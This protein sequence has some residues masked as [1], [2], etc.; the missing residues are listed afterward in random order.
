MKKTMIVGMI[1]AILLLGGCNS[2]NEAC[3]IELTD[4]DGFRHTYNGHKEGHNGELCCK[5]EAYDKSIENYHH[6][7]ICAD[8][9]QG[10]D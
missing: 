6:V 3:T 10:G 4:E 5:I 2:H 9:T 7:L 1:L 8:I